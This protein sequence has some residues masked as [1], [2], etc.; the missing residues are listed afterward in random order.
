M[1]L[2]AFKS[3]EKEKKCA[4]PGEERGGGHLALARI[5]RLPLLADLNKHGERVYKTLF[6]TI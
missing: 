5:F 1:L 3:H 6:D 4:D 2:C